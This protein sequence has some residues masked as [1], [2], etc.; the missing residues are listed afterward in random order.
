MDTPSRTNE[1]PR[2]MASSTRPSTLES[3][4]LQVSIQDL[5][6]SSDSSSEAEAVVDL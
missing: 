3:R 5:T 4:T 2:W 6:G 1:T